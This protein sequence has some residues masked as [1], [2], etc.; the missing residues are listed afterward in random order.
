M[1]KMKEFDKVIGYSSVKKEL[2]QVADVLRNASVYSALGVRAPKGLLL[3]GDPG[4]GKTLMATCLIEASGLK[5]FVCRKDKPDGDFVNAIKDTFDK[6][7]KNAPSVV[8]LDDMDKFANGDERYKD[9]EEYVSV[10]SC[11]DG[12]KNKAVFVLATANSI[13]ALP[14]SLLR[15]GRFDRVVKIDPPKGNDAVRIISHY[16]YGKKFASEIDPREIAAILNGRSCATLETV[17]NEAGLYAGFER[18][19]QITMEHFTKACLRTVYDVPADAFDDLDSESDCVELTLSR[20]ALHEAGHAVVSEVLCPGSVTLVATYGGNDGGGGFTAR[21]FSAIVDP[22]ERSAADVMGALGGRAATE[23]KLGITD[24]GSVSDLRKAFR[25]VYFMVAED[26]VNGLSLHGG[27]YA[28]SEDLMSSR[29]QAATAQMEIYYRRAKE[30][31][32]RNMPFLDALIAALTEK[33][34]LHAGDIRR[35]KA[36]CGC[37]DC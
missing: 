11:I 30:I 32:T 5:S 14:D 2:E 17:I 37:K 29:E 6:A 1:C 21:D 34:V 23:Q 4:V 19:E 12:I 24:G 25:W 27:P 35:I 36:E 7:A 9:A 33:R 26:C 31:I 15:A 10:Q 13:R 3:H 8:L 18:A 22:L 16:L 28:D 20:I